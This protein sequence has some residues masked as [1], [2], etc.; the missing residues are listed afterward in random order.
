MKNM[1]Q[2]RADDYTRQRAVKRDGPPIDRRGNWCECDPL[3]ITDEPAAPAK[4]WA[5]FLHLGQTDQNRAKK[6]KK[7]EPAG[8][9]APAA[10]PPEA[11]RVNPKR[12]QRDFKITK[13]SEAKGQ[14]AFSVDLIE[15]DLYRWE[16]KLHEFDQSS[17]IS[18]DLVQYNAKHGVVGFSRVTSNSHR[19]L[20]LSGCISQ[21]I[22]Q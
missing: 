14:C 5:I 22:I 11:L 12:L 8:G 1:L 10:G 16:I 6:S 20:S 18:R 19:I 13:E 4:M 9:L 15:E 21:E 2:V 17:Q 7:E 3:K